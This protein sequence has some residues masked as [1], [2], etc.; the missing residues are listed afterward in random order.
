MLLA[1]W[2]QRNMPHHRATKSDA[3]ADSGELANSIFRISF[4]CG[5]QANNNKQ[6]ESDIIGYKTHGGINF[7]SRPI[8]RFL[9]SLLAS[10]RSDAR[11]EWKFELSLNA[12]GKVCTRPPNDE[13]ETGKHSF[14]LSSINTFFAFFFQVRFLRGKRSSLKLAKR[15]NLWVS[16]ICQQTFTSA[17]SRKREAKKKLSHE[18]IIIGNKMES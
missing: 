13:P 12:T 8:Y 1:T 18:S 11:S 9:L 16:V 5:K 7:S 10:E 17:L 4:A 3:V 14:W 15:S 6:K 2:R